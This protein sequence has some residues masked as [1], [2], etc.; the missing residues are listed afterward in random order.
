MPQKTIRSLFSVSFTFIFV[1]LLTSL[2]T[3]AE[4]RHSRIQKLGSYLY[5]PK[6]DDPAFAK[7]NPR[8]APPPGPLLL[9]RGDRL[10]II[11]DSIT[12]QKIYSRI[13]ETY[14][15]A[16]VPQ[17]EISS[18][19]YGWSGERT[20]GFLN[21]MDKD[22][23]R[24]KPTIATLAYG[25]N[26]TRYRPFDMLNGKWYHDHYSEVVHKL[27]NSGARVIVGSPG[28]AGKIASWVKSRSGT[29]DEHNLHLCALRDIALRV[30]EEQEVAF[31][32]IFWPMYQQ[33]I[34][35]ARRYGTAETPYEIAGRDGIHPGGAG[36]LL[37]A[38]SFL[39]A[40]GLNGDIAT[41]KY[42]IQSDGATASAGHQI[43]ACENG[44]ISITS[45]RYPFCADGPLNRDD[46]IRSGMSLVPFNQHLNRFMLYV[47]GLDAQKA[48]ITWGQNSVVVDR[49]KLTKGVNLAVLFP[50]NPFSE[51]FKAVD[52]AVAAKQAYETQ[53]VKRVFHGSE[54]KRDMESAVAR[55]EKERATL[56][57]NISEAKTPVA[58][59]LI[60]QS[61]E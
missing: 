1:F 15:T 49:E 27:K 47:T 9:K 22:C 31:A 40:M 53:Q 16:C 57:T 37:M 46:S 24:F 25:M 33:Q 2:I 13:I 39:R 54:G 26:D 29:L 17:L 10:A 52:S 23:L 56:V 58:H 21:R 59:Q 30:S 7:F 45:E 48:R 28:C 14:L 34:L 38:Y 8:L 35:A 36:H 18:R 3:L 20:E 51:T 55:T 60:I 61:I 50:K 43:T 42:D 41:V 44:V 12:E 11:G 6:P 4:E 32:D 19:Q 5:E